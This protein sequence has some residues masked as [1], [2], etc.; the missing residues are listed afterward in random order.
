LFDLFEGVIRTDF[1]VL[2]GFYYFEKQKLSIPVTVING[3]EDYII[4]ES[5]IRLW[6]NKTTSIIDFLY[7]PGD[8]FFTFDMAK[9]LTGIIKQQLTAF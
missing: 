7:L 8:H 4:S 6:G 1:Y 9:E 5:D 3:T 2:A